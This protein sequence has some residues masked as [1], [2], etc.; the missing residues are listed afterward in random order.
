MGRFTAPKPDIPNIH[1]PPTA[2]LKTLTTLSNWIYTTIAIMKLF[3]L[4]S[5]DMWSVSAQIWSYVR[6]ADPID[7]A[8]TIHLTQ[9]LS[10][11]LLSL[12]VLSSSSLVVRQRFPFGWKPAHHVSVLLALIADLV[13]CRRLL[14]LVHD[15]ND[16]TS[17]GFGRQVPVDPMIIYSLAT[18][19]N[20]LSQLVLWR[21]LLNVVPQVDTLV[22]QGLIAFTFSRLAFVPAFGVASLWVSS[23]T[24]QRPVGS[25]EDKSTSWHESVAFSHGTTNMMTDFYLFALPLSAAFGD[26]GTSLPLANKVLTI[27]NRIICVVLCLLAASYRFGTTGDLVFGKLDVS[28][29]TKEFST[30]DLNISLMTHY[31]L[32]SSFFN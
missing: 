17:W 8:T 22:T 31:M 5:V 30:V 18:M 29:M 14:S 7:Q 1:P 3:S 11:V 27:H 10:W 23:D 28:S 21:E 25:G 26:K 15:Q 16:S 6:T 12:F 2:A 24:A 4:P 13:S 19:L 20:Q 32:A 9:L